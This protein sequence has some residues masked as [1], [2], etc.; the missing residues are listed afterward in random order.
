MSERQVKHA[1]E[2]SWNDLGYRMQSSSSESIV[3]F[4]IELLDTE[5]A[6]RVFSRD[7][8]SVDFHPSEYVWLTDPTV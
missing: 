8:A 1:G 2:I 4:R 6:V 5:Q 3:A 7:G